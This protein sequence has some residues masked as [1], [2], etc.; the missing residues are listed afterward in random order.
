MD[1]E[2]H[3]NHDEELENGGEEED[4]YKRPNDLP[5][6]LPRSLDDRKTYPSYGFGDETE[7]YDAWQGMAKARLNRLG[8]LG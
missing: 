7:M 5:P 2:H 8:L 3:E 4:G 6:D 1:H